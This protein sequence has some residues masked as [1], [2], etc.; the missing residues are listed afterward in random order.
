MLWD[1]CAVF[2]RNAFKIT[3]SATLQKL[4]FWRAWKGGRDNFI[5]NTRRTA[6]W[7]PAR[8]T[9]SRR[10]SV[11]DESFD[12]VTVSGNE[13]RNE[14][15][16]LTPTSLHPM[17]MLIFWPVLELFFCGFRHIND[18]LRPILHSHRRFSFHLF[19]WK[20]LV[21]GQEHGRDAFTALLSFPAISSRDCYFSKEILLGRDVFWARS[22]GERIETRSFLQRLGDDDLCSAAAVWSTEKV[23][24]TVLSL[25]RFLTPSATWHRKVSFFIDS[26]VVILRRLRYLSQKKND[27]HNLQKPQ[28]PIN[29]DKIFFYYERIWNRRMLLMISLV[30]VTTPALKTSC[31]CLTDWLCARCEMRKWIRGSINTGED[32]KVLRSDFLGSWEVDLS[33]WN[34]NTSGNWA[35]MCTSSN[36]TIYEGCLR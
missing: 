3:N 12:F 7:I 23:N 19:P 29:V 24:E 25:S 26:L 35:G 2:A 31:C 13:L 28:T 30:S 8:A 36:L 11:F 21:M 4:R 20:S 17:R 34:G 27:H 1:T 32:S 15:V 22:C 16:D 9:N 5:F 14:V 18:I 10:L 6:F 33:V